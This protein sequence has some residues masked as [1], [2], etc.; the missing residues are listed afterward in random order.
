MRHD[1]RQHVGELQL[2][3][4]GP[5]CDDG[6]ARGL[7]S[8]HHAML[9]DKWRLGAEGPEKSGRIHA[10]STWCTIRARVYGGRDDDEDG[11]GQVKVEGDGKL[12]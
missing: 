9:K 1:D 6:Q 11:V 12:E 2:G 4:D 7:V 3:C 8:M 10:Q 5:C